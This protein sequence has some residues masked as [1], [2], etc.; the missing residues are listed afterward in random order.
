MAKKSIILNVEDM[1]SADQMRHASGRLM[2]CHKLLKTISGSKDVENPQYLKDVAS[3]LEMLIKREKKSLKKDPKQDAEGFD[4][5]IN[6]IVLHLL[7]M[8]D[9]EL[10]QTINETA[11][12]GLMK[13]LGKCID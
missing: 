5:A 7:E 2:K 10:E 3:W 8:E 9:W 13:R 4:I 11:L 1:P 6:T 12:K